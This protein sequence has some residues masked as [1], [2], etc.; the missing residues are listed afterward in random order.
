MHKAKF[1]GL[2]PATRYYYR[3]GD[4]VTW[5]PEFHFRTAPTPGEGAGARWLLFGD[6]GTIMP[7]GF[8]V[9]EGMVDVHSRTP[10]DVTL[11]LGD[12]SYAGTGST[13]EWQIVWDLWGRQVEPLGAYFTYQN[14]MYDGGSGGMRRGGGSGPDCRRACASGNHEKYYNFTA[15]N[16]RFEMPGGSSADVDKNYFFSFDHGLVHVT[17]FCTEDYARPW[18]VGSAQYNWMREVR[19]ARC[20]TGSAQHRSGDC[21]SRV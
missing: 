9:T 8:M 15:Y 20:R 3:V 16:A 4:G 19:H 11:H 6:M 10:F 18:Q 7:L 2:A 21:P 12:V 13:R 17:S 5:S 14:S 1:V